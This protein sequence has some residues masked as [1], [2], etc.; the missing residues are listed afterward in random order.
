M[1]GRLA[2][3]QRINEYVTQQN[4]LYTPDLPLA[5]LPTS[6]PLQ[7]TDTTS[8]QPS[9][10]V[11]LARIEEDGLAPDEQFQL[12]REKAF[13]GQYEVA[14][15]IVRPLLEAY[16]DYHDVRLLLGRTYAWTHQF[17]TAREHFRAVLQR[18]ETYLD[19][20]NALADAERWAK[21]PQAALSVLDTGL[22]HHPETASLLTKKA[23]IL[24]IL[25][26]PGDAQTVVNRLEEVA[27]G[28]EAV[29]SLKQRI[30]S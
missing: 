14:R 24:L 15:A 1:E 21:R 4:K 27:P 25:D 19:A 30:R 7:P 20:Y 26:R 16:P 22:R 18:D 8:T 23:E 6:P 9:A 12:A 10:D 3:F 2:R 17:D 29:S 5:D 28:S 11:V 13:A